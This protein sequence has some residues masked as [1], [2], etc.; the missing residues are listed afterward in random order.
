M[1]TRPSSLHRDAAGNGAGGDYN[2]SRS[3]H[4][5]GVVERFVIAHDP[6][7][8]IHLRNEPVKIVFNGREYDSVE[9][10]PPEERQQYLLVVSALGDKDGDGVPD[11][12]QQSGSGDIQDSII[13]EGREYK[14]RSALPLEVREALERTPPL[15]PSQVKTRI[16]VKTRILPPKVTW[17]AREAGDVEHVRRSNQNFSWLVITLLLGIIVLLLCLWFSGTRPA[18]LLRR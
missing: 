17:S 3:A 8:S 12:L 7:E 5:K 11:I 1:G 4:R 15:Q 14:D 10:M 18:D 9:Q 13:Y 6:E 2:Q 16:E